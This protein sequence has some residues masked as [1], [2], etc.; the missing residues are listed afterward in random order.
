M[1]TGVGCLLFPGK[2]RRE[3]LLTVPCVNEEWKKREIIGLLWRKKV[4]IFGIGEP[5]IE[6]FLEYESNDEYR[7]RRLGMGRSQKMMREGR[8]CNTDPPRVLMGVD[9]C[10]RYGSRIVWIT[11]PKYPVV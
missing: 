5:H 11:E 8:V 10:G 4:D 2:G 6:G 3:E 7:L 1:T 9:G